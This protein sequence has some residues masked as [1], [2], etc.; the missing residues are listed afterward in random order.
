MFLVRRRGVITSGLAIDSVCLSWGL[1]TPYDIGDVLIKKYD[2]SK[3][4]F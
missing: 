1:L 2:F 3:I 4:C